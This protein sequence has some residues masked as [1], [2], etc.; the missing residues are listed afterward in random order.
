MNLFV[1]RWSHDAS[2]LL[3]HD[4]E[5]IF[6]IH[7]PDG[8]LKETT[9]SF[10]R[11]H[12]EEVDKVL[13]QLM[14]SLLNVL[15]RQMCDFLEGGTYGIPNFLPELSH[16]PLTNLL[17]E[18]VFGDLDYDISKS[19]H[20]TTH[21]RSSTNMLA[22]NKT[23]A[24]LHNQNNSDQLLAFARRKGKTLRK[25]HQHQEKIVK[26]RLQQKLQ[27]QRQRKAAREAKQAATVNAIIQ[28]LLAQGGPCKT[29]DD[30]D[31][32][33]SGLTERD[34]LNFLKDQI[35]YLK[36]VLNKKDRSLR[37]SGTKDE[38]ATSLKNHL[39]SSLDM[40][41]E[42]SE[43]T[44]EN[45]DISQDFTFEFKRQGEW[46]A[47]YY[48]NTFYVGQVTHII[49]TDK[50]YVKYLERSQLSNSFKWP[51]VE[52][53]AETPAYFV[54]RWDLD[55]IPLTNDLRQWKVNNLEDIVEAYER[56]KA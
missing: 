16:C 49:A 36:L 9:I 31:R 8:P 22:H 20:S 6:G 35:R 33:L 51:R 26:L 38:L 1:F 45:E 3:Q 18:N 4:F 23:S 12:R 2:S 47:V 29:P 43:E 55:V 39:S 34:A 17:G 15:R 21:H 5:G 50:A 52:D 56:L 19:R 10:A 32:L 54:F 11:N 44:F 24:W 46:V 37:L 42:G 14:P 27:E 53:E 48:D 25:D 41:W 30:V 40:A 7:F 13:Q 28:R